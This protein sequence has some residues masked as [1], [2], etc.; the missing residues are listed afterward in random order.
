MTLDKIIEKRRSIR[1]LEKTVVDEFQ[2]QTLAKTASL[3]PSCYNK[4]PWHYV[5][6]TAEEQLKGLYESLAP[7]NEWGYNASLIIAV[8]SK[9]SDDC[10]VK[11]REY[12]LFDTGMSTG[13]IILKA[14]EMGLSVHPIAGFDAKIAKS[15]L[16]IP[17]ENILIT[18]LMCGKQSDEILA[19]LNEEMKELE[20]HRPE[21]KRFE[22]FC[23][24]NKI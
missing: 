10:V 11:D 7:G 19:S 16:G 15:V 4:Q 5:F 1:S 6:V 14:V 24:L 20:T 9:I 21:R 2:I 18:L 13:F 22:E 12:Y 3:A 23:Y 17:E 8:Y